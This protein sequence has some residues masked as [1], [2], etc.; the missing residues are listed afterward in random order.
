MINLTILNILF[1]Y[2][3]GNLTFGPIDNSSLKNFIR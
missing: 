1:L 3:K 2:K